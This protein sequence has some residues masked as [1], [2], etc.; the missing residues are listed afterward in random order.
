M[1]LTAYRIQP[2]QGPL[3]RPAPHTREWMDESPDRFAYRCLPLV[4][5]N[6]H[7]WEILCPHAF[8]ATWNG[9]GQGSDVTVT[10]LGGT[11][12]NALGHFGGGVLTFHTGYVFRTPPEYD[13]YVSGPNNLPKDGLAPL[14]GVVET[15]WLPF[16]FTMNWAFTRPGVTIRFEAGEPFCLLFPV[17]RDAL[18][19][20]EPE[21][22][23]LAS[24]PELRTAYESWTTSRANFLSDLRVPDSEAQAQRWQKN[25]VRGTNP[26][27]MRAAAEHRT[28][29]RVKPFSE[30]PP[31]G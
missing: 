12:E 4:I 7:G 8:E 30:A 26:D 2:G 19:A 25:Y 13:L 3:I 16:P 24:E 17:P 23:D 15:G 5:A 28:R 10:P 18:E 20:V 22:R 21:V 14:T 9:G 31:R 27:G 1:K 11:G 6:S 29:L